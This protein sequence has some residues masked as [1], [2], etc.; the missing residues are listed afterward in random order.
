M[1]FCRRLN[2]RAIFFYSPLIYTKLHGILLRAVFYMLFG[3]FRA[4]MG[5]PPI[6]FPHAIAIRL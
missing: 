5:R 1:Y 3:G 2:W 6:P 4:N